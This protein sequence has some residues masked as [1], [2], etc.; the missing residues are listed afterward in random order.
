MANG[1]GDRYV[2]TVDAGSGSCRALVFDERAGLRG[3]IQQEWTYRPAPG[4]PGGLDFDT[5]DGWRQVC[6][7]VQGALAQA[8]IDPGQV[9]AVTAT[10]MREGFV[11]WDEAGNEIWGVPNVDARAGLEAAQLIADGL[12]EP[13]YRRGGDW[14]SLAAS[15]RLR[16][17]ERNDPDVFAR[18]K[19]LTMLG[20]WVLTRLSGE[21]ATDPSLGSSSGL[22]DLGSRDWSADTARDLHLGPILPRVAESGTVFGQVTAKAAEETGLR[23]GTPVV[24]GGADTQLGLLGGGAVDGTT[25]GL[26]GGTFWLTAAIT[27]EPV[28]DPGIRLRTLCHVVPD[29]WMIEGVGFVHGLSTR[30]VRDGLLRAANPSVSIEEGYDQLDAL[31]AEIP[32]GANGLSYLGSNVMNARSWKHAPTTLVG[33]SPFNIDGTGLGAVFR[34]VLEEGAYVARGHLDILKEVCPEPVEEL[35]FVGGPST[36]PLWS[37]IISDVLGV[38]VRVPDVTEA[39]CVGAALCALVGAGVYAD[40]G[41]AVR[42]QHTRSRTFEPNADAVAAYDDLYPA[43]RK[44]YDHL[45]AAADDGLAPHMWRG[46]GA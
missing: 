42:A 14:T 46:A 38:R 2:V 23:A 4:A 8:G 20:D 43:W 39:T 26:V 45:L 11:L 30:W 5:S 27:N 3:L 12:A 44:L 16:W 36:S 29:R 33:I 31:A 35:L 24:A 6:D 9:A 21:Y 15:A 18:A 25:Y 41:E 37:Q 10:S 17:V 28:I 22:F 34:A 7:C 40:L 13:I 32:P 19:H 1:S